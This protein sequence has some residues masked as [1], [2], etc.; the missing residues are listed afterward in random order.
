VRLNVNY[1]QRRLIRDGVG[2]QSDIDLTLSQENVL[3]AVIP[4]AYIVN[5]NIS[6]YSQ[7]EVAATMITYPMYPLNKEFYDYRIYEK[8]NMFSFVINISM[9]KVIYAIDLSDGARYACAN[10]PNK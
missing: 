2:R 1:L 9:Y 6:I 10:F 4:D 7:Q 5:E 3:A 8:I